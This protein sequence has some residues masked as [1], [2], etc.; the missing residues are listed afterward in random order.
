MNNTRMKE[1]NKSLIVLYNDN[2]RLYFT[3]TWQAAQYLETSQSFVKNCLKGK[4]K[5]CKGWHITTTN[6]GDI[7]WKDINPTK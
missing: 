3:N 4:F 2:G 1:N 6:D 5:Q 7:K